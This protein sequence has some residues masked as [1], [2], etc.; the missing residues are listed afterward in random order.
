MNRDGVNSRLALPL[1]YLRGVSA[2]L[3]RERDSRLLNNSTPP[4]PSS[5]DESGLLTVLQVLWRQKWAVLFCLVAGIASS[6]AYLSRA[7]ETF[8]AAGSIAVQSGIGASTLNLTGYATPQTKIDL[9]ADAELI[10]STVFLRKIVNAGLLDQVPNLA[11]GGDPIH[12]IREALDI[13]VST[14][15]SALLVGVDLNS[16]EGARAVVN[17][18][19]DRYS[20]YVTERRQAASASHLAQLEQEENQLAQELEKLDLQARALRSTPPVASS[21]SELTLEGVADREN[22]FID[23]L[24]QAELE[25]LSLNRLN[26]ML[27]ENGGDQVVLLGILAQLEQLGRV[28]E[29]LQRNHLLNNRASHLSREIETARK[30]YGDSSTVLS[31]LQD[32]MEVVRDHTDRETV[33][34]AQMLKIH[35]TE[36]IRFNSA[37]KEDLGKELRALRESAV[38]M[39]ERAA[40]LDQLR[41][42]TRR[43]ERTLDTIDTLYRQLLLASDSAGDASTILEDAVSWKT[44]PL[45][46]RIILL[47]VLAGLVSGM[48]LAFLRDMLTTT[49]QMSRREKIAPSLSRNG[50]DVLGSIPTLTGSP[51]PGELGPT[52]GPEKDAID[53]VAVSLLLDARQQDFKSILFTSASAGEGKSFLAGHLAESLARH[54]RR[55]LLIDLDLRSPRQA[56]QFEVDAEPGALEWLR[57]EADTPATVRDTKQP[58]LT[59][60]PAAIHDDGG[61]LLAGDNLGAKLA[62]LQNGYDLILID[63]GPVLAAPEAR[64]LAAT[65]D[66][67]LLIVRSGHAD[68]FGVMDAQTAL[69]GLSP[70]GF[71]VIV[72]RAPRRANITYGPGTGAAQPRSRA[73]RW[74]GGRATARVTSDPTKTAVPNAD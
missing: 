22:S 57:G 48:G 35:L 39:R 12:T 34:L 46:N 59:V 54:G 1:P 44:G 16:A 55:V 26:E 72:N 14:T 61:R 70:R 60:M 13:S 50:H 6:A 8:R 63:G 38:A 24:N 37:E 25:E 36:R 7:P 58:N 20:A 74:S 51:R 31:R 33:Q 5:T 15:G 27:Q 3:L 23:R 11:A 62:N 49:V 41:R 52:L 19:L 43:K 53:A 71:R 67:S 9:Y 2:R 10:D 47:G 40:K 29:T 21:I 18:V 68:E 66:L 69:E 64:F 4:T 17:A 32:E 56:D 42:E 73:S 28:P 65:A 30:R 45:P